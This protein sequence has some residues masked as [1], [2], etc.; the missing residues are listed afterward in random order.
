VIGPNRRAALAAL[1]AA[2]PTVAR[3]DASR[4]PEEVAADLIEAWTSIETALRSLVGGSVLSGQPLI[5]ELRGREIISLDQAHALLEFLA[6]RERVQRTDYRPRTDDITVARE[7]FAK[8]EQGL[9]E[10]DTPSATTP[11]GAGTVATAPAY[12]GDDTVIPAEPRRRRWLLF[13]LIGGAALLTILLALLLIDPFGLRAATRIARG[14]EA[15][16]AGRTARAQEEFALAARKDPDNA[17]PHI[18]L[19][20]IAR[21]ERDWG[22]A[23]RELQRAVE[24]EPRDALVQRELGA[25]FFA[26]GQFDAARRRYVEAIKLDSDDRVSMGY[27]GCSLIRMNRLQEGMSWITRAGAGDWSRCAPPMQPQMQQAP[28]GPVLPRP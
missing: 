27:L 11:V 25:L 10:M 14:R 4:H 22:T 19:G 18:Y 15:Y 21:E 8:L 2:R 7:A 23:A 16:A 26:R 24:L 13:A 6:V 1:T 3:L 9:T 5:R 28:G 17:T 20:R 12:V